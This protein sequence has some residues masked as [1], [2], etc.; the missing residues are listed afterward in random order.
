META[1]IS[2]ATKLEIE[3]KIICDEH[4]AEKLLFIQQIHD[5]QRTIILNHLNKE[6]EDDLLLIDTMDAKNKQLLNEQC[7]E[8]KQI[9]KQLHIAQREVQT[10]QTLIDTKYKKTIEELSKMNEDSLIIIAELNYVNNAYKEKLYDHEQTV[11]QM[12]N[13]LKL[14]NMEMTHLKQQTDNFKKKVKEMADANNAISSVLHERQNDYDKLLAKCNKMESEMNELKS[15]NEYESKLKDFKLKQYESELTDLKLA[16]NELE[17][18]F[19]S[20]K[21]TLKDLQSEIES[22]SMSHKAVIYEYKEKITSL[23]LQNETKNNEL[24]QLQKHKQSELNSW[25]AARNAM[26]KQ[27]ESKEKELKTLKSEHNDL[28]NEY[29]ANQQKMND[30]MKKYKSL[31]IE[32]KEKCREWDESLKLHR[33]ESNELRK[34][35]D[36]LMNIKINELN[37]KI[38]G[39]KQSLSV[40]QKEKK[41]QFE[42]LKSEKSTNERLMQTIEALQ[43]QA[44]A[45][46]AMKEELVSKAQLI[47]EYKENRLKNEERIR[48]QRSQLKQVR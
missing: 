42:S 13:D 2:D 1:Q 16:K 20:S 35:L 3:L 43:S 34:E 25:N 44:N 40:L 15:K 7:I 9:Y 14:K 47:E 45:L 46:N 5:L 28:S 11:I 41:K 12:D 39:Y 36:N 19:N 23:N 33:N 30:L 22:K 37:Q 31:S 29:K 6:S 26:S 18:M 10:E 24:M 27:M 8:Y 4:K 32:Y 17:N 38:V 21:Q 48:F